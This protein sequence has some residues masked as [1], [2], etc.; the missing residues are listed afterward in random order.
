[1]LNVEIKR[2]VFWFCVLNLQIY[3]LSPQTGYFDT[4]S[5]VVLKYQ[6]IT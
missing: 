4:F 5:F 6:D 2:V 3:N 1:M